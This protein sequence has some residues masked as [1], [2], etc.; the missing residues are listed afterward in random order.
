MCTLEC[1]FFVL[2]RQIE[3]VE[4]VATAIGR[5]CGI[6]AQAAI[7]R[8]SWFVLNLQQQDSA[9]AV[10]LRSSL[11]AAVLLYNNRRSAFRRAGTSERVEPVATAIC[12]SCNI[13]S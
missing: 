7:S 6:K 10:P 4:P 9:H 3:C 5:N 8:F 11:L 1:I 13:Q 12:R 2:H